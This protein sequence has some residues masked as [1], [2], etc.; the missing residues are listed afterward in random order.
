M[1]ALGFSA[2]V[3]NGAV[4]APRRTSS[5]SASSRRSAP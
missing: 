3:A 5:R 4:A 2:G 1:A